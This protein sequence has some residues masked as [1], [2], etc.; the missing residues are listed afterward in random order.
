MLV[1]HEIG[2]IVIDNYE[3]TLP[4]S[5]GLSSSAAVCVLV[6]SCNDCVCIPA[7]HWD[8]QACPPLPMA[9]AQVVHC[10]SLSASASMKGDRRCMCCVGS[11]SF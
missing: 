8:T 6:S 9:I 2:G 3:T 4:M 1:E 10:M 5:K 7:M 11:E